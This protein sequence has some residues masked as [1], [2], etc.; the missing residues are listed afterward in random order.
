MDAQG[1]EK[2]RPYIE[3]AKLSYIT[4][5]DEENKLGAIFGFKAIPNG[6]LLDESGVIRYTK[7]G[8]FDIRKSDYAQ[9]VS[10][11]IES[12]H[13]P[14]LAQTAQLPQTF[15]T[16]AALALFRQGLALYQQG[17]AQDA[18]ALWRK[19]VALEPD[20]FIIRKQIWV[21]EHPERFYRGD[22]DYAWQ[23]EQMAKGL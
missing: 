2:A 4:A 10:R 14:E 16:P 19:A 17:R 8:G 12:S 23:R 18:V 7:F 13:D 15:A 20:N 6:I 21:V 5:I 3:K 22:V 1:P 11:F 9:I